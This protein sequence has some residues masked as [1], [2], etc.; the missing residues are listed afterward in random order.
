[1][2]RFTE[3]YGPNSAPWVEDPTPAFTFIQQQLERGDKFAQDE[4]MIEALEDRDE[5]VKEILEKVPMDQR[6]WFNHLLDIVPKAVGYSP[7]HNHYM[8]HHANSL[9]RRLFKECGRRFALAG[10]IDEPDDVFFLLPPEIEHA[11][12]PPTRLN[13]RPTVNARKAK[14]EAD[15]KIEIQDR[16]RTLGRMTIQE[17]RPII[18]TDIILEKLVVG[19]L[20]EIR[21][22]LKADLY[23][24][25]G[26][27]G[28][29]EGIVRVIKTPKQFGE[30]QPGDVL[31]AVT[32]YSS[33]TPL[34][35][36]INAAIVDNGGS[37]SHAAIVGRESGIPV[38]LNTNEP[39]TQ[40]LKSGMKVRVDGSRGIVEILKS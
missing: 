11:L 1:M 4:L 33:W 19:A 13:W 21:P 25:C 5:A 31:V 37:L 40:K 20:P 22:E 6:D 38:V 36:S 16:P 9:M 23:G 15:T 3:F 30:V 35:S 34:F 28:V 26:A 2:P 27:P 10:A 18:T 24:V 7:E 12:L 29:A 8:D 39:A 32:T 17:A 14:W